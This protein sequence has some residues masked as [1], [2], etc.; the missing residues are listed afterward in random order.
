MLELNDELGGGSISLPPVPVHLLICIK[1]IFFLE[2][3][4]HFAPKTYFSASF[5]FGFVRSF[6][7][8]N[9]GYACAI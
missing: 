6:L 9:N 5:Y 4:S 7:G 1:Y 8:F 3:Y 2:N